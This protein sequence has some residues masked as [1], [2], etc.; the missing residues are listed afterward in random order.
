MESQK[1]NPSHPGRLVRLDLLSRLPLALGEEKVHYMRN[2]ARLR[3]RVAP[4]SVAA[5]RDGVVSARL[6]RLL[7]EDQE[8]RER[9]FELVTPAVHWGSELTSRRAQQH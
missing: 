7:E 9:R 1:G 6:L 4:I 3:H 8:R 5:L 2:E